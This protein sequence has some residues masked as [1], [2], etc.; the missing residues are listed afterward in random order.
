MKTRP[1]GELISPFGP[2]VW[3]GKLDEDIINDV[4]DII[5]SRRESALQ[6]AI[7]GDF[8]LSQMIKQ[9]LLMGSF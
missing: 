9:N 6:N 3:V 4:N 7:F 8:D 1:Q 5:E 2:P